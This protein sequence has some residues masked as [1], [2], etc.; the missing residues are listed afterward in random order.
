MSVTAQ[1]DSSTAPR[2]DISFMQ[3]AIKF[4]L[5]AA[6]YR[7]ERKLY[8]ESQLREMMPA[9][10]DIDDNASGEC[11]TPFGYTFPPYVVIEYGQSMNEWAQRNENKDFITIFQV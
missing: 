10:L 8:T 5:D 1:A 9:T 3:A 2:V 6:A 7:R 11:C 4:Y